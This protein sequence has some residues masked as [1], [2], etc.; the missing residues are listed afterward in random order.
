MLPVHLSTLVKSGRIS[1]SINVDT[2]I[3]YSDA[4]RDSFAARVTAAVSRTQDAAAVLP[5]QDEEDSD[6]WLNIDA[7]EFDNALMSGTT[8]QAEQPTG[9]DETTGMDEGPDDHFAKEQATRLQNLAEK[10]GAF[11]EGEGD[12]DGARFEE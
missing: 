1:L 2:D 12:V 8:R 10:V 4:T 9:V 3:A 7:Q 11:I 6:S 5:L